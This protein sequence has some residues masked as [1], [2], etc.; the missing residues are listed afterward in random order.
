MDFYLNNTPPHQKQVQKT[1][2]QFVSVMSV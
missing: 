1:P 2:P